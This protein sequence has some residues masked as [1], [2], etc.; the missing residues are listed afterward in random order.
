MRIFVSS[1]ITSEFCCRVA[2]LIYVKHFLCSVQFAWILN[3][4][5]MLVSK[6]VCIG[7]LILTSSH[8]AFYNL[9]DTGTKALCIMNVKEWS[10]WLISLEVLY[11]KCVMTYY[12]NSPN[13]PFKRNRLVPCIR[14]HFL[15]FSQYF[16]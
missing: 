12:Q 8:L 16:L 13:S 1:Y 2:E 5:G 11:R 6:I 3:G 7:N 14:I 9:K 4:Y 10:T 15:Y